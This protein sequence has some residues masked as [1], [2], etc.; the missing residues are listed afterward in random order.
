MEGDVAHLQ[1]YHGLQL[2]IGNQGHNSITAERDK[3]LPL[4]RPIDTIVGPVGINDDLTRVLRHAIHVLVKH[5]CVP[6]LGA[7]L[8]F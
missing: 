4:E 8:I 7:R 3:R 5:H 6:K 1:Q 2:R